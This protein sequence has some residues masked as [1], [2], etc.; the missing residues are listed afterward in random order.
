MPVSVTRQKRWDRRDLF[1]DVD[2]RLAPD[3]AARPTIRLPDGAK[4]ADVFARAAL[5]RAAIANDPVARSTTSA[6]AN[7]IVVQ[8]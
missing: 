1:T 4:T 7:K 3:I 5:T 6:V 8:R 2:D